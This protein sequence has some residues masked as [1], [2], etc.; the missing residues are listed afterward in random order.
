MEALPVYLKLKLTLAAVAIAA[1]ATPASAANVQDV[2]CF[3][4]SNVFAQKSDK[5]EGRKLAQATGLFYL[6]RLQDS[7]DADLRRMITRQEKVNIAPAAAGAE[8]QKCARAV[9][10][11]LQRLQ[12]LTSRPAPSAPPK[13]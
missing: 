13:K 8:M 7:G 5:E 12:S 10:T 11:G 9:Q 2:R 4:L 6:G 1:A 3:L